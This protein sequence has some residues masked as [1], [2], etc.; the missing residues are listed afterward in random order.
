MKSHEWLV[1]AEQTLTRADIGT[2]R[3][4]SLIL[5]EDALGVNRA[6]VLAHPETNLSSAQLLKLRKQLTRRATHEPLAYIRGFSEFYGRQFK[7][8]KRVLQPRPETETM[9]ALA[10]ELKLAPGATVVDV[11]TGSGCIAITMALQQPQLQ[12]LATDNDNNCLVVARQNVRALNA[13]V[14]CKLGNLTAPF[15]QQPIAVVL[16]NLPYVPDDFQIN[17]AALAEPRQAIYGGSDGLD[18]YRQLFKQLTKLPTK[19]QY[20]LT[21]ALPPQQAKLAALAKFH[22]YQLLKVDDFIQVFQAQAAPS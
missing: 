3:L 15:S 12:V 14:T 8:D 2:A 13:K 19:P 20:V 1:E 10:T 9:I 17:Q 6:Q 11:G 16:A 22:G 21:E 4:D 5:L 7:V 18:I